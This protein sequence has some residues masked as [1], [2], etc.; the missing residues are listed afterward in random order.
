MM[1][2]IDEVPLDDMI[3]CEEC[4]GA[5]FEGCYLY[6]LK[7]GKINREIILCYDCKENL[8]VSLENIE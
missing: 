1:V 6:Y 4:G 3:K 7:V 8:R 5:Y 2:E